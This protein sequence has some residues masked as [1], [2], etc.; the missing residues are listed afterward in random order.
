MIESNPVVA[1]LLADGLQRAGRTPDLTAAAERI[2]LIAGDARE[3]L[4][5]LPVAPDVVLLD[6]MFPE[7]VKSALVRQELRL[8]QLLDRKNCD[9][10][11]LLRAALAVAAKKVVVKRPLKASPLA[12]VPPSYTRRGRAVRFDVYVEGGKTSG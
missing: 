12:A 4:P 9:P 2:D 3:H 11:E 5:A 7:R 8:L 10:D 1:A 6:P